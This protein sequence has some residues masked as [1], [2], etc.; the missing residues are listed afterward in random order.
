MKEILP[1]LDY[2]REEPLY[3]QLYKYIKNE[4][5]ESRLKPEEKLPSIRSFSEKIGVSKTTIQTAYD[6]LLIEGYIYSK[7]KSGYYV[8]QII[9]E[10]KYENQD[11][12]K[13]NNE[14][15]IEPYLKQE[16]LKF[17]DD[18][19]FDFI[20]WKKCSNH[21]LTYNTRELLTEAD[22]QGELELREE[23]AR[24]VYQS[25]G[26]YCRAGEIVI[27]AGIQQIIVMLSVLLKKLDKQSI[28]FENPG[29]M[30]SQNIFKD[31][32]YRVSSIDLEDN[33]INIDILK[34]QDPDIVYISPSH[35]FPTGAVMPI[36]KRMQ[37]LSWA[38]EN[39][40]Y[41]IEDDYDSELRYTGK[42]IPALKGLDKNDKV[43]YIG[44]FSSTLLPSIRISYMVL[45]EPI[46][47][48]YSNIKDNYTQ[49]CSKVDQLILSKFMREG[50]YQKHI[51]RI[52]RIYAE[53]SSRITSLIKNEYSDVLK[54]VSNLSGLYVILEINTQKSE[55]D[56]VDEINSI[57]VKATAFS[58]YVK[59]L[60]KGSKPIIMLYFFNLNISK[61]DEIMSKIVQIIKV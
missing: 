45:P 53:K 39:E 9:T 22:V 11:V 20:K 5:Q 7:I 44:S 18:T 34:K 1:V 3:L 59:G 6:Q 17:H 58:Q 56:I 33:G 43:I 50:Y 12:E 37:I 15:Q 51:R 4:I 40:K 61:L 14:K 48:L 8:S 38:M 31:Y 23:I 26:V 41:I 16:Y 29:F 35:Q 32:S 42:P 60:S 46:R 13:L 47:F 24:Y 57:G 30:L 49:G 2:N 27:G 54:V 52:R 36:A 28:S 21:I 19:S 10:E 55:T 25:R